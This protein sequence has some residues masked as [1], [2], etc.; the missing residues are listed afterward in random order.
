MISVSRQ[1]VLTA[2]A[3]VRDQADAARTILTEEADG[4]GAFVLNVR[5]ND[6]LR[7]QGSTGCSTGL[8]SFDRRAAVILQAMSF[9]VCL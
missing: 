1:F 6:F 8:K 5:R 9:F 2:R 7:A 4:I 3:A